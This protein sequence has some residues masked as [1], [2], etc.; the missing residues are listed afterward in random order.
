MWNDFWAKYSE[1]DKKFISDVI[2]FLFLVALWGLTIWIFI[3]SPVQHHFRYLANNNVWFGEGW[4]YAEG[5]RESAVGVPVET[6]GRHYLRV[7]AKSD[8]IVITK[9]LDYTPSSEDYFCFRVRAQDVNLYVNGKSWYSHSITEAYRQY[10]MQMYMLHQV[11][12]KALRAG[13]QITLKLKTDKPTDYFIVQYPAMGD[14]YALTKYIIGQS[15]NSLGICAFAIMLIMLIMITRHSPV[16]VEKL[17]GAL[18]LKWLLAFLVTA[19]VYISMDSGC[20]ELFV[21]RMSVTNW[22][23]CTSLLLL[24]IPF[25]LYTQYAFFPSHIRYEILAG[26]EFLVVIVSIVAYT[27][28][29]CDMR[30][31]FVCV[32]IVVAAGIIACIASFIQEKMMPGLEVFLGYGAICITAVISVVVYWRGIWH[33]ASTMFGYGLVTFGLCM[34]IWTVRS[35]Y[36]MK[37]ESEEAERIIMQRDKQA[38]EDANEQKSRFLSH[39]SHEIRTPLNA[40]LGV[41]ELIMR[42]TEDENIKKYAADIQS[43][44]RTLLALINDVLDFS[45]IETGKMD[46][47][48]SDYSLSSILNDLV[49]MIQ[50]RV[51]DKGLELRLNINPEMPDLIYGDEIRI[52]QVILNLL[53][54]AV[55][56]TEQ[57]WIE[58]SVNMTSASEYL[59]E[60]D[61]VCLNVKVS[62]S[63]IG[64]KEEELPKLFVEFERLDRQHNKSI[65]GSG[66]GLSITSR[67]VQLMGGKILVESTY[68]EGSSFTVS[69]PQRVVSQEPIGDYKKR[70]ESLSNESQQETQENAVYPEKK[71]FVVDDNEMN[72]EVIAAILEM[73]EI[74]VDRAS[75]GAS[76]IAFLDKNKVD[77]ILTDDM[78]PE[79]SGT[80]MMEYLK[81]NKEGA[82]YQTPI[83][84]LTANAVVGAREEYINFG[85]DEYMTKPIDIDVLQKIL[86]KYLK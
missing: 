67:L 74:E 59:D 78:M 38:A 44:G 76:A 34:L 68:G 71:V 18:C 69:I 83:V 66:L 43:A 28:F 3:D 1:S 16:L 64:M 11:S 58:L 21:E 84:V 6:N 40:V 30:N 41:N 62:D 17:Q 46:I 4:Q 75:S 55:K 72:L 86:M 10:A 79:M 13:D 26:I 45:K 42:E 57:G 70:F 35:S 19:V 5:S 12:A 54:N 65:E 9:T 39:M 37:Q 61:K 53:T 52:K 60:T 85:F 7:D 49:M 29:A 20:M 31:F 77:L 50:K 82:N 2:Y 47:V 36:E 51:T 23:K 24:P 8:S 80:Q 15:N 22:L 48:E 81:S 63:G 27:V 25:I 73:L 56:Y 32:H 33:P 14:R